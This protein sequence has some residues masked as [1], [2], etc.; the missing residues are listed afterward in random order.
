MT[1]HDAFLVDEHPGGHVDEAEKRA[2]RMIRVDEGR[3]RGVRGVVKGAGCP[4]PG[5]V[6][7]DGDDLEALTSDLL[8]DFLPTWQVP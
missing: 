8:V 4:L 7:C 3:V 2:Q 1:H 6:L 5:R